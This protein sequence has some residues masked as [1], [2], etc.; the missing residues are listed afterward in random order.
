M[1][2]SGLGFGSRH[3]YGLA[4]GPDNSL[5][6]GNR[7]ARTARAK[8]GLSPTRKW[9]RTVSAAPDTALAASSIPDKCGAAR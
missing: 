7:G 4:F 1:V 8:I 3:I 9:P 5:N 2:S 6:S